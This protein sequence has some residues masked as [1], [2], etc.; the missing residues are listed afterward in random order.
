MESVS[1]GVLCLSPVMVAI[2]SRETIRLQSNSRVDSIVRK[3]T[4]QGN[5]RPIPELAGDRMFRDTLG[6]RLRGAYL[7][8]HRMAN[9]HFEPLGVTADQFVILTLLAHEKGLTQREIVARAYS[10]PNTIGEMLSRL[11]GKRLVR[12]ERHPRDGRARVVSLTVKGR[13]AQKQLWES[14]EGR[15][16]K[17]DD[18]FGPREL[19]TLNRLLSHIPDAVAESGD[20]V[21]RAVA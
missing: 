1:I 15:L 10:D 18:A 4:S 6:M 9:A 8:F 13:N 12:R 14:W 20:A 16:Q 11:E 19:K 21:G 2:E 7:T 3:R 17:I 5:G